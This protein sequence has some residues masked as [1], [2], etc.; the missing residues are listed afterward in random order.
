[1]SAFDL[2]ARERDEL[3]N[4]RVSGYR[5]W[6]QAVRKLIPTPRGAAR[7]NVTQIV[8]DSGAATTGEAVDALLA[9]FLRMP[10]SS[11]LRDAFIG[12]L[13]EELGTSDLSRAQT[14]ME[15]PLRMVTHLIM[16]TPEYQIN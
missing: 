10:V 7:I 14:Y 5:A 8:R 12:F 3:F 2:A 11:E 16:S 6:E 1:M 13:D 4:T 9:R 15:D